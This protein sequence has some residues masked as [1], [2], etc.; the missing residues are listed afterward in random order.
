MNMELDGLLGRVSGLGI[1]LSVVCLLLKPL[2]SDWLPFVRIGGT[3]LILGMLLE[4]L[5]DLLREIS[6]T[7]GEGSVAPY[8]QVMIRALGIALLCKIATDVCRDAGEAALGSGVEMAGKMCILF[9]CLPLIRELLSF[10]AMLLE[11]V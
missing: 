8:A 9:L 3:V 4:P 7:V 6:D 11:G 1:L 10:A 5:S 2:R